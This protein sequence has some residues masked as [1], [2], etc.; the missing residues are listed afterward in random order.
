M[1]NRQ[2]KQLLAIL[3]IALMTATALLTGEK[4]IVFPE[5][6][7][8][9][10]GAW[11]A[12]KQPWNVN[13]PRLVIAMTIAAFAGIGIARIDGIPLLGKVVIGMIITTSLLLISRT[14]MVPLIS[15]CILPVLLGTTTLI[16]PISVMIMAAIIAILQ[17]FVQHPEGYVPNQYSRNDY[18]NWIKRIVIFLAIIALPCVFEIKLFFAPPLIVTFV[19]LSNPKS[20]LRDKYLRVII[21]VVSA[22]VIGSAAQYILGYKLGMPVLCAVIAMVL[23]L[24]V[25]EFTKVMFP[26][27]GAICLLPMLLEPNILWTYPIL[28]SI[29][30]VVFVMSAKLFFRD[31][32]TMSSLSRRLE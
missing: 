29:G 11:I 16:Y 12:D 1:K 5:I 15:A 23:I 24:I 9:V 32:E 20:G 6:A 2:K 22:S 17:K 21:D 25:F 30:C 14:T 4:E 26:P 18:I 3:M 19:E 7:A 10:I 31:N 27:A 13:G 8:L 28:V